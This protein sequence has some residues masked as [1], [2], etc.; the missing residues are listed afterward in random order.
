MC[1]RI[2]VHCWK[3]CK[4]KGT[5]SCKTYKVLKKTL[6]GFKYIATKKKNCKTNIHFFI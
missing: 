2:Y 1:C 6:M 3:N 5:N 4:Y